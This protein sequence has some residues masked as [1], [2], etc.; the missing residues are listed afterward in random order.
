LAALPEYL[1]MANMQADLALQLL[2]AVAR[3]R[4]GLLINP[5]TSRALP[6][7]M[8]CIDP[9]NKEEVTAATAAWGLSQD[10]AAAGIAQLKAVRQQLIQ[11][12][13]QTAVGP[14]VQ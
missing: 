10:V 8:Y 14:A 5:D 1:Q 9:G 4:Y 12:Q 7:I 3:R 13:Q 11:Q 2:A 6:L